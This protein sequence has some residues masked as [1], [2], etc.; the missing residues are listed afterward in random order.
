MAALI[1]PEEYFDALEAIL[2]LSEEAIQELRL[3]LESVP[4]SISEHILS[5]DAAAKIRT[6]P[7]DEVEDIIEMLTSFSFVRHKARIS[8]EEFVDDLV[9]AAEDQELA[10]ADVLEQRGDLFRERLISLLDSKALTIAT[11]A[12][13]VLVDHEHDLCS[14]DLLTDIRPVFES[15]EDATASS[16]VIVHTLKLSYHQN[17]RIKEFFVTMDTEDLD[18]LSR[19]IERTKSKAEN[20]KAIVKA[21]NLSYIDVK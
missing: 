18:R 9:E 14:V 1:I 17:N 19:L 2:T 5:E 21:A 7:S 8:T 15:D 3:A 20:L 13:S 4:V 16:A 6:I 10:E 12:R 11:K